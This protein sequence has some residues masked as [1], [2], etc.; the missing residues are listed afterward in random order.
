MQIK[1]TKGF[2][3]D[4]LKFVIIGDSGNGKTF[5]ASTIKEKCLVVSAEAGTLSL[6]QFD[7]DLVDLTTSNDGEPIPKEKRINRLTEVY[8]F[9]ANEKHEYQWV[10]I[11]S[12][13]E[14]SQ[15][16]LDALS[17]EFPARKDSLVMYGE[18]AKKMRGIIKAFR[19]LPLNVV[20]TCLSNVEKDENNQRFLGARLVGKIADELPCFFDEVFY[21]QVFKND[22]G[23]HER[24]LITGRDDR[25][26]A[27]DRS[28]RLDQFEKANLQMIAD[29]IRG[30]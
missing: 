9:L 21:L 7:I 19:D 20:F 12:L 8:R 11:D 22:D 24:R 14:I 5:L 3:A 18:N 13:T 30:K 17:V 6:N 2:Q 4:R 25:I 10:F 29:K 28:G 15:N 26:M 27:K 16:L 1:N 23:Q